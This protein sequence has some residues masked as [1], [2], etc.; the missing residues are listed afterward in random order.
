MAWPLTDTYKS[1]LISWSGISLFCMMIPYGQTQKLASHVTPMKARCLKCFVLWDHLLNETYCFFPRA[2]FLKSSS[3]I[4]SGLVS[5]Q[6]LTPS[7][8]AVNGLHVQPWYAQLWF[9]HWGCWSSVHSNALSCINMAHWESGRMPLCW[10]QRFCSISSL[11][12]QGSPTM[13][14]SPTSIQRAN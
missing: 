9:H 14:C 6:A 11:A 4:R 12:V 2:T 13:H 8:A 1:Q 10:R 5:I 3:F 7:S